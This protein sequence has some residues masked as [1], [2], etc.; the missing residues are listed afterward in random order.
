[1]EVRG[2]DGKLLMKWDKLKKRI[3]ILKNK[4]L[5]EIEFNEEGE[6]KTIEQK[7]NKK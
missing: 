6:P 5:Y 7:N 4:I 2:K 3:S 1:M